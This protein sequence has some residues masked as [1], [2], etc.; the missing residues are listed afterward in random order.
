[1]AILLMQGSFVVVLVAW[2]LRLM[3]SAVAEQEFSLM[4]AGTL[5]SLA[6]AAIVVSY[7]M[8]GSCLGFVG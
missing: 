2:A 5:V 7:F 4:L 3:E 1:V 8:L 6:A